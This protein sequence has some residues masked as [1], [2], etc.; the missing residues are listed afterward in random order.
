MLNIHIGKKWNLQQ[1]QNKTKQNKKASSKWNLSVPVAQHA[2][3][4][5]WKLSVGLVSDLG[6]GYMFKLEN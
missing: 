5:V 2:M 6:L 4:D 3:F 1:K